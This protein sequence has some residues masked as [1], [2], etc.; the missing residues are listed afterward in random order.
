MGEIV[1]FV[2]SNC[3]H[4]KSYFLGLG[5]RNSKE[6]TLYECVN[7]RALKASVLSIPKCSKCK[8]SS[9][10]KLDDYE[11]GLKQGESKIY[12]ITG[13]LKF[14]VNYVDGVKQ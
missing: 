13:E 9:L 12:R 14:T 7:C 1:G 4:D 3:N 8:K 6:K 10:I 11:K 2:C 5:F